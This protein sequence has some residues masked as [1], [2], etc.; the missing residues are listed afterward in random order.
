MAYASK[1]Y[2]PVKAHEYYMRTRELKGYEDRYGGSRGDGT[3]AASNGGVPIESKKTE[4]QKR[5][6]ANASHNQGLKDKISA[7]QAAKAKIQALRDRLKNMSKEDRKANRES[8]M[9]QIDALREQSRDEIQ[10]LREQTKGG[11]TSGFNEKGKE[12]AAYIKNQMEKKRDEVI[13]KTNKDC[14]NEMLASVERL[15]ADIKAM[16]ES[17]SGF[18]HKQ[19]A[20]RIKAMLGETK[21]KKIRAKRKHTANYKQKYKDEIDKLRSDKSMY[22]YYDKKAERTASKLEQKARK[23]EEKARKAEEKA[24]RK[25]RKLKTNSSG[26]GVIGINLG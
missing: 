1:Y 13:K 4:A 23:A 7:N 14:D 3:S 25:V 20:A 10:S 26:Q 6:E 19:F 24:K 8:I 9:E 15:A 12:A 18:S 2:D 21:K 16:R 22:S 17:G 11:H 5:S